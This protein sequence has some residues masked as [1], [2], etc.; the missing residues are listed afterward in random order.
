VLDTPVSEAELMMRKTLKET[1]HETARNRS[2]YK[3][4]RNSM[5]MKMHISHP[6]AELVAIIIID[7]KSSDNMDNTW[8]MDKASRPLEPSSPLTASSISEDQPRSAGRRMHLPI[9]ALHRDDLPRATTPEHSSI[10]A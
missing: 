2:T 10:R 1:D 3:Q 7:D 8:I 9:E 5:E 6:E 4:Q